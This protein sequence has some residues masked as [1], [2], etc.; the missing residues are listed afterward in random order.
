MKITDYLTPALV[1][2]DLEASDKDEALSA[3]AAAVAGALPDLPAARVLAVLRERE[4]LGSTGIGNG[5]AIPHGKL[6]ELEKIVVLFA[7]SRRGIRFAAVDGE[8]VHL[9]FM[10]LAPEDS[11]GGHLRALARISCLLRDRDFCARLLQADDAPTLFAMIRE[12][13][14]RG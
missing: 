5:I 7:R 9:F 2:A 13:D 10:L 12:A 1:V 14:E 11:A 3:L 4:A 8:P 6:G